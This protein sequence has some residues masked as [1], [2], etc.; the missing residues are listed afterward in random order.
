ML[1]MERKKEIV[2]NFIK[3]M[4]FREKGI[5][6]KKK[7][8]LLWIL[9]KKFKWNTLFREGVEIM[10]ECEWLLLIY[11]K[12][13]AKSN[14]NGKEIRELESKEEFISPLTLDSIMF[15]KIRKLI[16]EA[17]HP[18]VRQFSKSFELHYF[19]NCGLKHTW[20]S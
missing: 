4:F 15:K 7:I 18:D 8:L 1:N 6:S 2:K 20:Y 16:P 10:M 14:P 9:A 17:I 13:N 19:S 5:R 3:Q 12:R 11:K